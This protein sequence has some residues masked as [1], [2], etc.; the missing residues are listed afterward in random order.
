MLP[1]HPD[2]EHV[3]KICAYN[4]KIIGNLKRHIRVV[5]QINHMSP[6]CRY[7]DMNTSQSDTDSGESIEDESIEDNA[8]EDDSKEDIFSNIPALIK[9]NARL[10]HFLCTCKNEHRNILVRFLKED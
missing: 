8:M 2:N 3:C 1:L 10:L 4:T 5:H 6:V 7:C 9:K